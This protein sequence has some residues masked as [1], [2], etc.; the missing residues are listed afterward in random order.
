MSPAMPLRLRIL[1]ALL[2]APAA[3]LP[4]QQ[5][6][7]PFTNGRAFDVRCERDATLPIES[8]EAQLVL[9]RDT[10]TALGTPSPAESARI[11]QLADAIRTRLRL[12][13]ESS[14]AHAL[15]RAPTAEQQE[16]GDPV[17]GTLA[18]LVLRFGNTGALDSVRVTR[19]GDWRGLVDS[20]LVALSD[21]EQAGAL[22]T[23]AG[24]EPQTLPVEL[25]ALMAPPRNA[26]TVGRLS[27]PFI[28]LDTVAHPTRT[29]RAEYPRDLLASGIEGGVRLRFVIDAGGQVVRSTFEDVES[30]HPEFSQA[31][32]DAVLRQ[33]FRPAVAGAC[34][35]P[36][37]VV[38]PMF[39][40]IGG[41]AGR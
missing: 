4:A 14:L 3:T 17:T 10:S 20:V 11:A 18:R 31:A 28:M 25:V 38:Q 16:P 23:I 19:A 22:R 1:A 32:R 12:P 8:L 24:N 26:A 36:L 9:R 35:V 41:D 39:F 37:V 34:R 13:P 21:A 2:L 33:R 29:T 6:T 15:T 30:T 40:R 5:I 27:F 7:L